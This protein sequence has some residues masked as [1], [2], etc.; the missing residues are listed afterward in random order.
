MSLRMKK[1]DTFI[2]YRSIF[3]SAQVLPSDERLTFYEAVMKYSMDFE[4]PVLDGVAAA[5]F[6]LLKPTLSKSNTQFINGS[7]PKRKPTRS[8]NEA[9]PKP[10]ANNK[11]KDKD[12]EEDKDKAF[13]KN[14]QKKKNDFTYP[15]GYENIWQVWEDYRKEINKPLTD[16]ARAIQVKMLF[17]NKLNFIEIIETSIQ[18]R[19]T[20]LFPLKQQKANNTQN[21]LID[22]FFEKQPIEAEV[23]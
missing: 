3:E 12:K 2:F 13:K 16:R 1:R 8:Q 5:L 10:N 22:K 20:G 14:K 18:N 17:E 15:F 4:E 21:D 7:K 23:L 11:D 6:I 19:W 9:N